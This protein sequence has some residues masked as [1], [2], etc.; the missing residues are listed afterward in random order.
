[1]LALV[2]FL[3]TFGSFQPAG[4]KVEKS[5]STSKLNFAYKHRKI[6]IQG[7]R[8]Q[9][10]RNQGIRNHDTRNQAI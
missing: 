9:G 5:A 2:T 8:N 4:I 3:R 6:A 1:L 10:I 7:I